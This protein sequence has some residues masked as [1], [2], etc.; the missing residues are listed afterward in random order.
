MKV[1]QL[2][3]VILSEIGLEGQADLKVFGGQVKA[4]KDLEEEKVPV[5]DMI[6]GEESKHED[7]EEP[8]NEEPKEGEVELDDKVSLKDICNDQS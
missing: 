7:E 4:E 1:K 2:K 5:Q 3:K 8:H 6:M